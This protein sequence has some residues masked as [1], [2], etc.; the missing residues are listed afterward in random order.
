MNIYQQIWDADQSGSGIRPILAGGAADADHGYVVVAPEAEGDA[1]TRLLPEVVIPASKM[2]T[3]ELVRALFDNYAL[4]ERD[5]ESETAYE[6]EEVHNLLEA[7][8][9][10]APM[11]VARR[12]ASALHEASMIVDL[13][14]S[15]SAA[16]ARACVECPGFEARSHER[17]E[18]L[19]SHLNA[20]T[21]LWHERRWLLERSKQNALDYLTLADR[22]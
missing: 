17:C 16:I 19:A 18:A 20:V 12:Y 13:R 2:R 4:D 9:D 22:P 14:V 5:P 15:R 8:V 10:S 1:D 11:Q 3:Y 6:R 7:V 21:E